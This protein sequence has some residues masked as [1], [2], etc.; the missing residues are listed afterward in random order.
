MSD[1]LLPELNTEFKER[2]CLN[3]KSSPKWAQ[4]FGWF[5]S[6]FLL[7]KGVLLFYKRVL[8]KFPRWCKTK[9]SIILSWV[10]PLPP[11]PS[12]SKG[13]ER[14]DGGQATYPRA[15]DTPFTLPTG[16]KL[17]HWV[18]KTQRGEASE[19]HMATC[20]LKDL[21]VLLAKPN[22]LPLFFSLPLRATYH[23]RVLTCKL[24]QK[25]NL[26]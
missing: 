12:L 13:R 9:T 3:P 4:T 6:C 16:D 10:L 19:M 11:D 2:A 5:K 23:L 25:C 26:Y 21:W 17:L 15:E 1:F 7:E 22:L 24:D 8:K 20:W 14:R 18:K